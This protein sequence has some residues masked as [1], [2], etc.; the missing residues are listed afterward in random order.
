VKG[1]SEVGAIG[2]FLETLG[3]LSMT[4]AKQKRALMVIDGIDHARDEDAKRVLDAV[5]GALERD[6]GLKVLLTT[7]K[8]DSSL[9]DGLKVADLAEFVGLDGRTMS[10]TN[11]GERE[12]ESR[13]DGG[14]TDDIRR[15]VASRLA[16]LLQLVD[17]E[18][19]V[20]AVEGSFADA[21]RICRDVLETAAPERALDG[22]LYREAVRRHGM[23]HVK[24]I[25][26]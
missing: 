8:E 25:L 18:R 13:G 16:V 12:G 19:V 24:V 14:D 3:G 10:L 11:G 6:R 15:Y 9:L 1:K 5:K 2:A 22:V 23:E 4:D 20:E 26:V 21:V 17:Q 7:Q